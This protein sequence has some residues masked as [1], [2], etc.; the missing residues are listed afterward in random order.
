MSQGELQ[1]AA[2]GLRHLLEELAADALGQLPELQLR[3]ECERDVLVEADRG[4][5]RYALAEVV[6]NARRECMI[7]VPDSPSM[8]FTG[9]RRDARVHIAIEDNA[10]PVNVP[11][12]S[13]P[14]AEDAST[15][16]S[17]GRGSGL[18]LAIVKETFM[19]HGGR[20][21]LTENITVE[22]SRRPGVTFSADLAV[23]GVKEESTDV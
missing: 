17:L 1:L 3:V 6:S 8:I 10:L 13:D 19:R 23:A 21:R 9:V 7:N 20:C 15:Y 12:L 18:G 2:F 14:F 16:R 11:L 4:L 22:N 5:V